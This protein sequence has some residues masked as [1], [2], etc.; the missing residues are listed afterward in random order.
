M[1][2]K[3]TSGRISIITRFGS[4]I[5]RYFSKLIKRINE[6]GF[7]V[8]W[9]CDPMHGNTRIINNVKTRYFSDILEEIKYFKEIRMQKISIRRV[10]PEITPENVTE[11]LGGQVICHLVI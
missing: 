4:K 1:N 10:A 5:G 9:C 7:N 2:P 3:N 11:C 8:L 6:N